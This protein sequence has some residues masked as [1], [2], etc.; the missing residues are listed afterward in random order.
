MKRLVPGF[1]RELWYRF[2]EAGGWNRLDFLSGIRTGLN[3]GS[4]RLSEKA[5]TD[6]QIKCASLALGY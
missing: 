5:L 3:F 4:V 2:T 1:P 6:A